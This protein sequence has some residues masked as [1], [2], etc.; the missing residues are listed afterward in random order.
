M[1]IQE[2]CVRLSTYVVFVDY[3]SE[4]EIQHTVRDTTCRIERS[5]HEDLLRFQGFREPEERHTRW[6][7]AGVLVPPFKDNPE[8]HGGLRPGSEAQ[9]ARD[10]QDWYWRHEIESEREYRWLGRSVVKMPTD[11]FF[12][13][14][15]MA[16]HRIHCVLEIG[17]GD[18]G[19]L[20]FFA[21]MLQLLGG[22]LVIGVDHD[23]GP[24]PQV[25]QSLEG[26]RITL[27]QGDA[28]TRS[29]VAVARALVPD[30][31]GLLVLDAAPDPKGKLQLLDRWAPLVAPGGYIA[32]EDVDS[33][34]SP[35][36]QRLVAD[37]IDRFLLDNPT[38]GISS[39][40]GRAPLLKSRGAVLHR[41]DHQGM[42]VTGVARPGSRPQE[43]R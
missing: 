4:V 22:G 30:G 26:V 6:I 37:G 16:A 7:D 25:F 1:T 18:G 36:A 41:V 32:V 14:E 3:G 23:G 43:D 13:Q 15:L 38:F 9:L 11:L 28:Y 20:W 29:T 24:A 8:Y 39:L 31:F 10:Y 17:Y 40:A 19:G 21:T 34:H 5:V 42:S 35:G 33:P 2:R 27:I 12:Y